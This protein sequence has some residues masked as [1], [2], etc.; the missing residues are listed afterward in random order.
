MVLSV[1]VEL[2]QLQVDSKGK[3]LQE[4]GLRSEDAMCSV[5]LED[6]ALV[7]LSANQCGTDDSPLDSQTS[8]IFSQPLISQKKGPFFPLYFLT[9]KIAIVICWIPAHYDILYCRT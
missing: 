1:A 8:G 9:H 5:N 7:R 6:N 4:P 3:S 2:P